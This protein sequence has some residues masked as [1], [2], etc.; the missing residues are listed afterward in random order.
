MAGKPDWL[1]NKEYLKK[2][3]GDK[4]R[5]AASLPALIR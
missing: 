1:P 3:A 2:L 5:N 4:R